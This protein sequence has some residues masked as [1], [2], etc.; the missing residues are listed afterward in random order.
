[1]CYDAAF[2]TFEPKTYVDRFH[3]EFH[4]GQQ[5]I[6]FYHTTGFDHFEIPVITGEDP[7]HI[8]LYSWGLIPF[9]AKDPADAEKR[10]RQGLN[11]RGEEMFEKPFFK[12]AA[13]NR[14]CLILMDGF[15]EHHH[16]HGMT[17]PY[18]IR[19]KSHEPFA[20]AGI[21]QKWKDRQHDIERYTVALLTTDAN[22]MMAHIHNQPKFSKEPRMPVILPQE[23]ESTWIK[24][25][26][27][28]EEITDMVK[29]FD[30]SLMES[31]TVPRLKGKVAVG[32]KPEAMQQHC[33]PELESEQGSLF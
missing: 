8:Q 32:N 20:V 21:W 24:E 30:E 22:P 9:W 7:G 11:A 29:P 26:L 17:F 10:R 15:F 5:P 4:N 31:F 6:P 25:G 28:K 13:A 3:A 18:H 12:E 1:M 14:R 23:L 19:M 2:G 27:S 33:Y 16:A